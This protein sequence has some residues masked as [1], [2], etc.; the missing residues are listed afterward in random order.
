MIAIKSTNTEQ[1]NDICIIISMFMAFGDH[2]LQVTQGNNGDCCVP[3]L[4]IVV[5]VNPALG[6]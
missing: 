6:M 3:V 5:V 1:N 4:V 2:L